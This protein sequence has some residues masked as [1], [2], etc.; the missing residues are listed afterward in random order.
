MGRKVGKQDYLSRDEGEALIAAAYDAVRDPAMPPTLAALFNR[1]A[2]TATTA[3]YRRLFFEILPSHKAASAAFATPL[4]GLQH[5]TLAILA[6]IC[7]EGEAFESHITRLHRNEKTA[8]FLSRLFS[9][10]GRGEM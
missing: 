10:L 3:D 2:A 5:L 9:A 8:P 6:R 7:G 4:A 1:A